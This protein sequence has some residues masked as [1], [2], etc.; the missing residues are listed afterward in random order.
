VLQNGKEV[1]QDSGKEKS[2]VKTLAEGNILDLFPDAQTSQKRLFVLGTTCDGVQK[3]FADKKVQKSVHDDN[4]KAPSEKDFRIGY[5]CKKGL[6][7]ESPNQDDFCILVTDTVSIFGVFDGHGPYGHEIASYTHERLPEAVIK[8]DRFREDPK[9]ALRDAFPRTHDKLCADAAKEGTFDCTLSGT[10]ATIALLKEGQLYV[11]NVGDS[12]AVL[13]RGARGSELKAHELTRDHKP[14]DKAEKQRIIESGRGQ[15]RQLEGDIPLRVFLKDKMYP[16]LAMTRSIGDTVGVDAGVISDPDVEET[17]TIQQD[18]RFLLVCSDGVWEF[19]NP[20][21]A[22]NIVAR[23]SPSDCMKGAEALAS[24]SWNRWIQEEGNV[25]DD[26]TV[27]V[28]WF[29]DK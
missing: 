25:V 1:T 20:Q 29:S 17:G 14:D 27:I 7:P 2:S 24:E 4:I 9:Q 12:K 3:G 15:V 28:S 23:Y 8:H 11:A 6:K 13:A 10:T 16:G 18:W 26:I 21:E 5:S 22:V 19:I